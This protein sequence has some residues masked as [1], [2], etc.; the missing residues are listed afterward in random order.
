[1][2]EAPPQILMDDIHDLGLSRSLCSM[3][4]INGCPTLKMLLAKPMAEWFDLSGFSQ[5][6][7]NEL[8]NF[9]EGNSLNSY[10]KD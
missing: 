3:L 8:M 1:M 9:L 10:I 6:C 4:I 5:H 7:L 2:T